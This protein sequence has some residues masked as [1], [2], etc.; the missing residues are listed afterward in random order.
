MASDFFIVHTLACLPPECKR[1]N[2][3]RSRL[4]LLYVVI[5]LTMS[6]L[7]DRIE[8]LM[9]TMKWE[10]S[11]VVKI[12]GVS[13]SAVSQWRGKGSK[14]IHSIGDIKAAEKL[15]AASGFNALWIA[16]GEGPKFS[17]KAN[18]TERQAIDGLVPLISF[19]QAGVWSEIIDT[20]QPGDAEEWL[21]CP[22]RHSKSTFSLTVEGESM[23]NPGAKP[24]YEPGDII[25]VDPE[26]AANPGDRVVVRL[27]G[28]K[29]ATF[30]QLMEE[31]GR[32]FLKALNPEWT[33][34]Y[35]ELDD[36]ATICGVV[37]GRFVKE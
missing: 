6:K 10:P 24:S 3:K 32:R 16:K 26:R 21:P 17:E 19:V 14:I 7:K 1:A 2:S 20:F 34:R 35:I 33:P 25:Y 4:T 5:V 9:A 29:Q 22:V 36:D 37:I 30:K 8:E 12:A 27:D 11:D 13:S 23:R 18:T 15:E 28:H 31:D